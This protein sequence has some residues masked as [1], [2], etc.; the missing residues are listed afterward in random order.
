MRCLADSYDIWKENMRMYICTSPRMRP[1]TF[2]C[3]AFALIALSMPSSAQN[4]HTNT[5]SAQAELHLNVMVVPVVIPPQH[6]KY[7]G[8]EDVS[9]SYNLSQREQQFS[10]TEEVRPMLVTTEGK[11]PEQQRVQLTTVVAK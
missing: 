2:A 6:H 10:V 5:N 4:R 7:K 1:L 3:T 11:R 9:V 8:R